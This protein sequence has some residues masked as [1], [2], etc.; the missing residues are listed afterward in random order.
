M[1]DQLW[2]PFNDAAADLG[3]IVNIVWCLVLGIWLLYRGRRNRDTYDEPTKDWLLTL[4]LMFFL[5]LYAASENLLQDAR[6]GWRIPLTS[7]AL[8]FGTRAL[9][10]SHDSHNTKE[11]R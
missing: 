2:F 11:D 4:V 10:R 5:S 8:A 7:L 9:W 3:R 6:P 1:D